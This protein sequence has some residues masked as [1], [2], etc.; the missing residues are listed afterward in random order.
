MRTTMAERK[1]MALDVPEPIK[2]QSL[3]NLKLIEEKQKTRS[4][5]EKTQNMIVFACVFKAYFKLGVSADPSYVQKKIGIR[6]SIGKSLKDYAPEIRLTID[7]LAVFYTDI[8]V[9]TKHLKDRRDE[10]TIGLVKFVKQCTEETGP[11]TN[12]LGSNYTINCAIGIATF[13]LFEIVGLELD[14]KC[15]SEVCSLTSCCI[16]KYRKS[17]EDVYNE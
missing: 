16:N 8:Y 5:K 12:W 9:A 6:T 4:F 11:V 7:A 10:L 15:W 1:I 14:M 2:I 17:F 3:R 13:Y